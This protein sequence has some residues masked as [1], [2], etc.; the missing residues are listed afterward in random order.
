MTFCASEGMNVESYIDASFS[1]HPDA[2]G[3]TGI[4]ITLGNGAI[5]SRSSN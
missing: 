1:V 4:V 3:Q 2:K 5:Y